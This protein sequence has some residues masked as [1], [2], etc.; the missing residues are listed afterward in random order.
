MRF[1]A[2]PDF[3]PTPS[4]DSAASQ[5]TTSLMVAEAS[6]HELSEPPE[7]ATQPEPSSQPEATLATVTAPE[8]EPHH[9]SA[10]AA[11]AVATFGSFAAAEEAATVETPSED[12]RIATAIQRVLDRLKPQIV[13]E[14]ARELSKKDPD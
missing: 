3:E 5:E 4:V 11:A 13:S 8:P 9:T 10:L 2:S 6:A 14:I 7:V 1:S 12:D